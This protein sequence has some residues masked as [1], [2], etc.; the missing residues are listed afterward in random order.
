MAGSGNTTRRMHVPDVLR[1]YEQ[2]AGGSAG[3]V[4]PWGLG[5]ADEDDVR[6]AAETAFEAGEVRDPEGP[7]ST[8]EGSVIRDYLVG[9]VRA[10]RP[11]YRVAF[12]AEIDAT[13]GF[14]RGD[15]PRIALVYDEDGVDDTFDAG[16]AQL[17][18]LTKG[19]GPVVPAAVPG[20]GST[21][22]SRQAARLGMS[23]RT[24]QRRRADLRKAGIEPDRE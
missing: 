3:S 23:K 2:T 17:R 21:T 24:L 1:L 16:A 18:R 5:P 12:V 4:V 20:L 7:W 9:L 6:S 19:T 8:K 10:R 22:V 11:R 15:P 13:S 14:P